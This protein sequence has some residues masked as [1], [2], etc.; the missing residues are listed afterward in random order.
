MP[1]G[2]AVRPTAVQVLARAPVVVALLHTALAVAL[3][4]RGVH[5]AAFRARSDSPRLP[6]ATA[7][8]VQG[9]VS[10]AS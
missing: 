9:S 6:G 7:R 1:S 8:R 5:A 2:S 3:A 4:K 10:S